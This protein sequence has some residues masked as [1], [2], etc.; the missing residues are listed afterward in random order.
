MNHSINY[1]ALAAALLRDEPRRSEPFHEGLAA[2]L[3]NRIEDAPVTSPYKAGSVEDDAFFAGRMRAH[4]E[5]RNALTGA[6]GDREQAIARLQ[7]LAGDTD[8]RV[9]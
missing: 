3:Q 9:A 7:Q 8:R 1:L 5:F 6:N 2:V 4:N